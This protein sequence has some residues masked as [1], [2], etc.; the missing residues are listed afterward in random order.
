MLAVALSLLSATWGL[1]CYSY[2][3]QQHQLETATQVCNRVEDINEGMLLEI[4]TVEEIETQVDI[5]ESELES[6]RGELVDA[7]DRFILA[8]RQ[9]LAGTI[10]DYPTLQVLNYL[11]TYE[12]MEQ[13]V[14]GYESL[15]NVRYECELLDR[16]WLGDAP[17]VTVHFSQTG[18]ERGMYSVEELIEHGE[19]LF[20]ASFNA[21][22]GAGRPILTGDQRFRQRRDG[23]DGFNRISGP[24][25]NACSGCH[26]LPR[27]GGGGD[28]VANVFVLGQR[29]EFVDFDDQ[30]E[31]DWR[32]EL[33]DRLQYEQEDEFSLNL[34]NV[35]N[36][37]NTVGM[38]GSG[39]VELLAR[40]MTRELLA[41]EA[42]IIAEAKK[43]GWPV[44]RDISAKG[45][46]FG[47]ITAHPNGFVYTSEVEG[48][49]GDLIVR[50][51]SQKGV[52]RSLRE[53]TNEALLHHHGI[54]NYERV[55]SYIDRDG[56]GVVN[57]LT[58]GDATA[59][60]V[61]MA[62]LEAPLPRLPEDPD[63]R[64]IVEH[65][66][67]TF[68]A[69]GC[70]TCHVPELP[71]ES[72]VFTEPS[73][74]NVGRDLR[75]DAV[76][77]LVEIDLSEFAGELRQDEN[78]HYLIPV[79]SDLRRH[80]MGEDEALDNELVIQAGVPTY[81]WM[82]RRLWGFA[83]EPPFL[84][85]GRATLISEAIAAHGGDATEERDAFFALDAD[86]RDAVIAFLKTLTIPAE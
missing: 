2:S 54:E 46:D 70:A 77:G 85:H 41:Q 74:F 37:R 51:F 67:A 20:N 15:E 61:F 58:P 43:T 71:L 53:F 32:S 10:Y 59:L 17:A 48:V 63:E 86:D 14:E 35:G 75:A 82:T 5:L 4:L 34:K 68:D 49:A 11:D 83:S 44:K 7:T 72:L 19:M 8:L 45:V 1:A 52:F 3:E 78:G 66:R 69:V 28:N 38:F 33:E 27:I 26:T 24:D 56:D 55:G 16:K 42:D 62:T 18:I 80:D 6:V 47:S 39:F 79:F 64:A 23:V 50:P 22:D 84:H 81:E 65:G 13:H 21:L 9:I 30:L 60:V 36:E 73:E 25:A 57:E 40:E 76:E 29:F 12:H 31:F